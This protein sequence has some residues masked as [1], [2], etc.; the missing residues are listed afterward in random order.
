MTR[1]A[2]TRERDARKAVWEAIF[3]WGA[4]RPGIDADRASKKIDAALDAYADVLRTP[5]PHEGDE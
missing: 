5:T 4:A 3:R 2:E 1:P